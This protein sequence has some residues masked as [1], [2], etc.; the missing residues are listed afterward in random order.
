MKHT[1]FTLVLF[2]ISTVLFSQ[3]DVVVKVN[4][5]NEQKYEFSTVID[6]EASAV[7]SQGNTGTCWSFS[8]SS[9][10]ESEIF[11]FHCCGNNWRVNSVWYIH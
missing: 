11:N 1:F 6:I 10:L 3:E 2:L 9:F 4:I 5:P 8:A 7:K